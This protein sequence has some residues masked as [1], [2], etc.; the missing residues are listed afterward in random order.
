[1][2]TPTGVTLAEYN[3]A[4]LAEKPTH[5]R[6]VF[7]LQNV[8]LTDRDISA[9]GGISV[10]SYLN[11]NDDLCAGTAMMSEIVIRFINSSVFAGFDWTEE[12]RVDFGVEISNSIEWVTIGY[13]KGKKP[14]RTVRVDVID[15]TAYDRMQKFN[16]L[17]DEYLASIT[18][19]ETIGNIYHGLCTFLGIGY[20]AGNEIADSM[21]LSYDESPFPKGISC[22]Q[23]LSWIAEANCCMA[24]IT[25]AGNVKLMWYSDQ[26]ANYSLTGRQ[27]FDLFVDE[28]T[29]P[30]IDAVRIASTDEN[31]TGFIYPVSNSNPY[32]ILDN[33]LLLN[34]GTSEK[35][36]YITEVISRFSNIGTY[37]PVTVSAVG[38][39]VVE[40]G[41]IIEVVYD[42]GNSV[43]NMPVFNRVMVWA[44]GC[45]DGYQCTG[46]TERTDP[47][48]AA[49]EQYE[50]GGK[51]SDKYTIV[52][53]V[54]I[55]EDGVTVSG[56]KYVRIRSGGVFDVES[57]NMDVDSDDGYIALKNIKDHV[58]YSL[59][60][61]KHD[62][63]DDQHTLLVQFGGNY[64][65]GLFW[66][67]DTE[68][69]GTKLRHYC[70]LRLIQFD[71]AV[72][73]AMFRLFGVSGIAYE[74]NKST[75][76]EYV[77]AAYGNAKFTNLFLDHLYGNAVRNNLT[78]QST[79]YGYALDARQGKAL[80]DLIDTA[81][82]NIGN[83]VVGG[84]IS[85]SVTGSSSQQTVRI[86]LTNG[87]WFMIISMP[88]INRVWVGLVVCGSDS[89]V[90]VQQINSS[91]GMT[92]ETG[93]NRI[94][95]K[96]TYS[97]DANFQVVAIPLR[98]TNMPTFH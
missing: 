10:T 39:W 66:I 82:T 29:V 22:R 93:T 21:A 64:G 92:V 72:G 79:D 75:G 81:N 54:D 46:K 5:V 38:N 73:G 20:E 84:R 87:C 96:F 23:L 47:V 78:A 94:N 32:T 30:V 17:A 16:T 43:V 11:P 85:K 14:E 76:T 25:A 28:S 91:T 4:V 49:K 71:E 63:L 8:T 34:L 69:I 12:F 41:D 58:P 65:N 88:G 1:M 89:A 80:K 3:A 7:P 59:F 62:Y 98:G 86:D 24:K 50:L 33:P 60:L 77:S 2:L 36:A 95:C 27:Y 67:D 45:E 9:N 37:T 44:A 18:Y 57:T 56:S 97:S 51:L 90:Y 48:E 26:T 40:T 74:Y 83:C 61:G 13:F 31:I 6:I 42:N 52:S 68:T 70:G 19:P 35:T 55:D 15:F 53:G